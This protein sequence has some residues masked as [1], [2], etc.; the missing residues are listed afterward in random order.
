MGACTVT[1]HELDDV[2]SRALVDIDEGHTFWEI[3]VFQH[4]VTIEGAIVRLCPPASIT[5]AQLADVERQVRE[6]GAAAVK[7]SRREVAAPGVLPRMTKHVQGGE[8]RDLNHREIVLALGLRAAPS[9][10]GPELRAVLERALEEGEKQ[11][12]PV[13]RP[14][15]SEPLYVKSVRLMN[16]QRFRGRHEVLLGPTVYAITAEHEEHSGRSNWLGKSTFLGAI[17]FALFGWHTRPC[18]DAWITDGEDEGGVAVT[19]SDETVVMR[20]RT[21]GK[22]TRVT[23]RRQD[24]SQAHGDEAEREIAE[25]AGLAQADFFSSSFFVQKTIGQFVTMLPSKRQ[26]LVAG[27]LDLGSLRAAEDWA[28]EHLDA[29]A[30]REHEARQARARWEREASAIEQGYG[31]PGGAEQVEATIEQWI[32]EREALLKEAQERAGAARV[33]GQ[34]VRQRQA[35]EYAR[36]VR[37]RAEAELRTAEQAVI[38]VDLPALQWKRDEAREAEAKARSDNDAAARD[39]GEKRRLLVAGFDGRCPVAQIECPAAAQINSRR[40]DAEIRHDGA[41]QRLHESS[42][43][44]DLAHRTARGLD[45]QVRATELNAQALLERRRSLEAA[46]Q[47]EEALGPMPPEVVNG[48]TPEQVDARVR[49]LAREV[50][51]SRVALKRYQDA[52]GLRDEAQ[53]I[54]DDNARQVRLYGLA[55]RLLG[56]GEGGAQREIALSALATIEASTNQSLAAAGVE[57]TV[58][59]RW[60]TESTTELATHCGACGAS[61]PAS[62][63]VKTCPR[64]GAAR[65]PKLDEKL[66]FTLS[67]R[68]GAAED[69]AGFHLQIAAAAWLYGRR[70]VPWRVIAVDEP[71][72]ALDEAHRKAMGAHVAGLLRSRYAFEQAFVIAHDIG[73]TDAMPARIRIIAGR[74]GSR[75][76]VES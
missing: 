8:H 43:A 29:A 44:Y 74:D 46:V 73:S 18:E 6:A 45:Q 30:V 15:A 10:Q 57:L 47:A 24:G 28:R 19:L 56:R 76:E 32:A 33:A 17:P 27:W 4:G 58:S 25:R 42:A 34:V 3:G 20:S 11:A 5:D 59:L 7:V 71:F 36:A 52:R 70:G 23:L 41:E 50:E 35:I 49:E 61:L 2:D 51:H 67:D 64:C 68:S 12:K 72:G 55:A 65:G 37:A 66:D 69:L 63:R 40:A 75:V 16:W 22:A 39:E 60:G 1:I 38:G 9:E 62:K 31:N 21:R 14:R 53:A 48:E 13:L 26:A 54:A